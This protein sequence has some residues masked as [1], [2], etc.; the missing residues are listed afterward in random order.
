MELYEDDIM[1]NMSVKLRWVIPLWWVYRWYDGFY[2]ASWVSWSKQFCWYFIYEPIYVYN[3]YI[4]C[5]IVGCSI[6]DLWAIKWIAHLQFR[7]QM[8][9]Y[10]HFTFRKNSWRLGK[11]KTN[12]ILGNGRWIFGGTI[13]KIKQHFKFNHLRNDSI[14]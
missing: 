8:I 3:I 12:L 14:Y 5:L 10:F 1:V 4:L 2:L 11:T 6:D 13:I 7:D 9:L